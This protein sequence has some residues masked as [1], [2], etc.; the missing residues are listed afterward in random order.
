MSIKDNG[1]PAFPSEQGETLSGEWNQTYDSGMT[2]RDYFAGQALAGMTANPEFE[3]AWQ[4][5]EEVNKVSHEQ[6]IIAVS[7]VTYELSDA[8]IKE[9]DN[10]S[11]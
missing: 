1:G 6:W 2:L 8:M 11:H 4:E 5:I 3:K 10:D 7:K 9:R